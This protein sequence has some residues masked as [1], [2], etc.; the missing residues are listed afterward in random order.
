MMSNNERPGGYSLV[1]IV[2]SISFLVY[3]LGGYNYFLSV[4][5]KTVV[6]VLVTVLCYA[7]YLWASQVD[8][9]GPLEKVIYGFFT[10]SVGFLTAWGLRGLDNLL[11]V[12]P[13]TVQGWA[14]GKLVEAVPICAAML[15]FDQGR[16]AIQGLSG[17]DV[18]RSLMYGVAASLL[19]FV[20]YFA[21]VGAYV[22]SVTMLLDLLPWLLLFGLSNG[23]MEEL[24]FRGMFFGGYGE[25]FGERGAL[26]LV[27]M[28]FA[29]FHV[30][31]L[32]F[33]GVP[34]MLGFVFFLFFQGYAW[35]YLLQRTGSI[36]G[37]VLAHAVA[38]I[39]FVVAA[40]TG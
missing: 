6:K 40:F 9:N 7:A 37:A 4:N 22:P 36:W 29:L 28:V 33:M 32:P 19:G 39:L 23:F 15:V 20:Q 12:D 38:D 27:S 11:P 18:R 24:M 21:L 10:V 14:V 17:G 16:G 3:T 5:Q 31:L 26:L 34:L 35:G 25:L 8:P 1:I 13:D 2:V 30:T